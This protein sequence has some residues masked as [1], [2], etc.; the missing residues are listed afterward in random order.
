M[1]N[2][3]INKKAEPEIGSAY[4]YF[5][6]LKPRVMS[7]AIFTALVGQI[8]ALQNNT[9]HPLLTLFSLFSIA[10]G[11][12]GAGCINMWYDR[13]IDSIMD[14]TK[15]RPI[16]Q[17]LI[18]PAEA[19][20]LGIILSILATLLLTLSANITAG[21]LLASSILFYV[22]IYTMWLKRKTYHN[23]VIGGAAGALPPLIG[24]ASVSN[25]ISLYPIILFLIIFI[26]T[27]PHF[28]AL[29]LYT[30]EDYK[31]ANIP[32]LPVLLGK[33]QTI[34]SIIK[35]SFFLYLFSLL[36]YFFNYSGT[37]YFI[38]AIIT[39]SFFIYLA[40]KLK[41]DSVKSA[42]NLFR[43]S[44]LYLFILYLVLVIDSFFI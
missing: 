26:W 19:L 27:P 37:F 42:K 40:F 11:A 43:Y 14:R 41:E 2:N 21:I 34:K 10:I 12:G 44:I 9:N 5:I 32:M 18:K 36:P 22:F 1:F 6:L 16:P 15:S 24:W 20:S 17:G 8:L 25:D 29:S 4:S 35:Y 38:T 33:K 13:D 23:I 28:W 31:K 7:L 3:I 30:N 39:G